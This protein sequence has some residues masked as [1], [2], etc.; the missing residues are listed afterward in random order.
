MKYVQVFSL[1]LIIII[2]HYDKSNPS[3]INILIDNIKK[4]IK[5]FFPEKILIFAKTQEDNQLFSR[6]LLKEDITP[7]FLLSSVSGENLKQL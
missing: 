7:V 3:E 6:T 1:P 2:T 5:E 4:K